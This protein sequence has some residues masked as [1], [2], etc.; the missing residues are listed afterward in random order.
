MIKVQDRDAEGRCKLVTGEPRTVAPVG[1]I[2]APSDS[3]LPHGAYLAPCVRR[4]S[5]LV[6]PVITSYAGCNDG[7]GR[8]R[9]RLLEGV[10]ASPSGSAAIVWRA[11]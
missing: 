10:R 9:P 3:I 4:K 6:N 8:V 11:L 2:P 5:R 7:V 1:D